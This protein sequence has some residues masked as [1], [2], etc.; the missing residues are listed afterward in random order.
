AWEEARQQADRTRFFVQSSQRYP[1]TGHGRINTYAIF[2]E[3]MRCVIN[4]K[5]RVGC[6]V[7][8]GIATD[9]ST[10]L[11]FQEITESKTLISLFDFENRE[12][13]FPSVDSR[14]KFC[15]L[16]LGGPARPIKHGAQFVYFA[17]MVDDLNDEE[18]RFMLSSDDINLLNPNTRTCPIFRSQ[19]DA[20][21]TKSIYRHVPI[22]IRESDPNDNLWGITTKPGL[23]NMAGDSE[24]FR[25]QSQLEDDEWQLEGN[26]FHKGDEKYLPLYEGKMFDFYDHRAANVVI[27]ATATLRQGQPEDLTLEEHQSPWVFPQ[28]RYWVPEKEVN[29]RLVGQ[30][31]RK[32]LLGWKEITSSTNERTLI[33]G[34][35]PRYGIG[36]KIPIVL[37]N[38]SNEISSPFLV[39]CLSSFA[40]DFVARQKLGG[41]SLT[42]FTFKQLPV[43]APSAFTA[44]CPWSSQALS[45]WLTYRLLELIY[46]AWDLEDF[47]FDYGYSG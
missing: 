18:R 10:K 7:P 22:L 23:F 3:N 46:T 15:L 6:I 1:L 31:G 12:K 32:W 30:W 45:K 21:L 33:P 44:L 14:Y 40:C 5:G 27:S 47:A 2:A 42:P 19:R 39:A 38:E 16:T 17:Y 4:S 36:H 28:P 26:I 13:L 43:F 34:I 35:F 8:S 11:F 20:E 9:D 37:P 41:F 29:R 25:T 24:L